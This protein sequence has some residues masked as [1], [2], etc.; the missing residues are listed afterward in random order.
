MFAKSLNPE[1][2]KL[3]SLYGKLPTKKKT[4]LDGAVRDRKF[5]D[6]YALSL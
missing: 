4:L 1:E 5:F 6:S 2:Q 3:F